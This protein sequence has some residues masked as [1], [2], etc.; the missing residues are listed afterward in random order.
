VAISEVDVERT[1]QAG[2]FAE[3]TRR[4]MELGNRGPI[5]FDTDG[6]LHP[7][8]LDAYWRCGFYVFTDVI[9]AEELDEL[10]AEVE[11]VLDRAPHPRKGSPIDRFGRP[12]L[13][14]GMAVDPWNMAKPLSDPVG[15]THKNHGRH[16]SKM[17]EPAPPPD[18]PEEVPYLVFGC[19]ETMD[20]FLRVYGHPGLLRVA[21]AVNGPDF[22]PFNEALFVKLP[23]LGPSVAWHQDGQL[24]WDKPDWDEGTHGFNFQLQLYGSTAG[25]GVWVVPGTHKLGKIDIKALV[26][27]N[28]GNERLPGAVP[29]I[30]QP[31]D[32][33]MTNRQ[34]LHGSFANTS[35]D[36]RVTVNFGFHRYRSVINQVGALTAKGKLYD[37]AYVRQRCRCIAVAV[38]ARA[39]RFGDEERYVYQPFVGLE[40][41]NRFDDD[42]RLSVLK[43]YNLRDLAI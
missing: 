6:R 5:R 21:E 32:C 29:L 15:G 39:Q 42:T 13:G 11:A 22:T 33:F 1:S 19:L 17:H 23:G 24:H 20:S 10:R 26:D 3:G 25:N 31:G 16:P 4:A 30:G 43:D 34:T 38:D 41:E 8:I 27:A 12:A 37:E 35:P 7:D 18:A 14:T 9:G 36:K 40:D 28:G 2:Y